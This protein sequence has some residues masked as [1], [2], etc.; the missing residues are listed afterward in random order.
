MSPQGKIRHS[1]IQHVEEVL[2]ESLGRLYREKVAD[3][4]RPEGISEGEYWARIWIEVSQTVLDSMTYLQEAWRLK[5]KIL[6]H[7]DGL[8]EAR[9][10]QTFDE[11]V[12][13]LQTEE[14][15]TYTLTTKFQ[16]W[17][18]E[19]LIPEEPRKVDEIGCTCNNPPGRPID[20][21]SEDCPE[22][23]G[24]ENNCPCD[25]TRGIN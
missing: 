2:G 20:D 4:P 11:F 14:S 10:E 12:H 7:L 8:S 17:A 6:S 15:E 16:K 9:P 21:H 13:Q 24:E 22:F 18:D 1:E 3:N 25:N 19:F 23:V 5:Q